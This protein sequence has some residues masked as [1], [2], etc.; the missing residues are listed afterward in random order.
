MEMTTM[1][2][3]IPKHLHSAFKI[4]TI[5]KRCTMTTLLLGFIKEVI[6]KDEQK[7]KK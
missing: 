7:S 4:A 5:N 3:I 1:T 2:I 6:K